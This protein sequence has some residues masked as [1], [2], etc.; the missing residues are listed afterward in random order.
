[1]L[2]DYD[3]D[4]SMYQTRAT[5]TVYINIGTV[6]AFFTWIKTNQKVKELQYPIDTLDE[7]RKDMNIE[8]NK[9]H[10]EPEELKTLFEDNN[11]LLQRI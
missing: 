9:R 2:L 4:T 10:F 6:R 8:S 7:A 3:V 11:K 5:S 1:M